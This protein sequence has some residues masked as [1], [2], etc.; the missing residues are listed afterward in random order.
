M[1]GPGGAWWRPGPR[2][3]PGRSR[4]PRAGSPGGR[5][6]R[7]ATGRPSGRRRPGTAPACRSRT[8]RAGRGRPRSPGRGGPGPWPPSGASRA[9]RRP[10]G[11]PPAAPPPRPHPASGG[12]SGGR[13]PRSRRTRSL[14]GAWPGPGRKASWSWVCHR[15]PGVLS[16]RLGRKTRRPAIGFGRGPRNRESGWPGRIMVPSPKSPHESTWPSR[17][18]SPD[19]H[20]AGPGPPPVSP[21]WNETMLPAIRDGRKKIR[22]SRSRSARGPRS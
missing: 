1:P 20:N 5:G 7:P 12:R 8:P 13:R 3:S 18:I 22:R 17:G 16:R 2:A 4:T 15:P 9:R 6:P 19:A 11:P 14:P 21:S 10:P